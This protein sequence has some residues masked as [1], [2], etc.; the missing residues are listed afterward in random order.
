MSLWN[1]IIN[2]YECDKKQPYSLKWAVLIAHIYKSFALPSFGVFG[3]WNVICP[4]LA[5]F[6]FPIFCPVIFQHRTML[7]SHSLR[8]L[9]ILLSLTLSTAFLLFFFFFF[10]NSSFFAIDIVKLYLLQ[11]PSPNHPNSVCGVVASEFSKP[12]FKSVL[13]Y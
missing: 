7:H 4:I 8:I 11:E 6:T 13:C 12:K 10:L 1:K 3:Q 5:Q 2:F 9:Y